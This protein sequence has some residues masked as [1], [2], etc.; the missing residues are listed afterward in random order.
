MRPESLA[1]L[2][3]NGKGLRRPGEGLHSDP[4]LCKLA[5]SPWTGGT[6]LARKFIDGRILASQFEARL[7]QA[8]SAMREKLGSS[9]RIVEVAYVDRKW[10][11]HFQGFGNQFEP[12]SARV[13][14]F[15]AEVCRF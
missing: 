9:P 12:S 11:E 3:S 10:Y 15:Q 8:N 7:C 13:S 5:G 14:S 6:F 1:I 4:A 2:R